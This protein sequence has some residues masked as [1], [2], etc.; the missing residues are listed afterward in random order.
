MTLLAFLLLQ[1]APD[2]AADVFERVRMPAAADVAAWT[3][4]GPEYGRLFDVVLR[5]DVWLAA[6]R[7]CE[8]RLGRFGDD[9]T[10][11]VKLMEWDGT[12]VATGRRKGTE[13]LVGFNLRRLGEYE[14][15]M[16]E[17]RRRAEELRN[18]R[19]R[20]IWKV[21]PIRYERLVAHE[22]VHVL[23]G[24]D[25]SPLWFHEGLASWVGDDPSYVIA[26]A[27]SKAEVKP[28]DADGLDLEATY[29]RGMAFFK[30]LEV[31][32]GRATVRAVFESTALKGLGWRE[33]LEKATGRTWTELRDAEHDW[34][35]AYVERN[36]TKE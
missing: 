16:E 34:S 30:W 21:P 25:P 4:K 15:R 28:V 3:E 7:L 32:H 6:I 33:A 35:R 19:K 1:A 9:W 13:G 20:M 31:R 2:R 11:D 26:F 10:I 23:Q 27:F 12:E 8:E 29:G 24:E 14:R 17:H 18:Q 22:L 5:R 36:R